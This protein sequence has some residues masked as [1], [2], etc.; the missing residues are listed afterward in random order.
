M[1]NKVTTIDECI[2]PLI[3]AVPGALDGKEDCLLSLN[4]AGKAVLFDATL[5][6]THVMVSK[7]Q[8][9]ESAIAARK[10][11][12]EGT[13]RVIQHA[14]IAPG[15]RVMGDANGHVVTATAGARSLGFKL[16]RAGLGNGAGGDVIEI[17]D[18]VEQPHIATAVADLG[19]LAST[20]GTFAAA[21]DLAAAKSEGEKV[22]DDVRLVAAKLA[23]LI[24]ALKTQKILS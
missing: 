22:G 8:A 12:A 16:D 18:V 4:G 14:A 23:E 3:E 15:A 13:V 1:S 2:H 7:L 6:A 9:G 24:A 21:A 5:P 20:D 17:S 10:L 11:G 19:A